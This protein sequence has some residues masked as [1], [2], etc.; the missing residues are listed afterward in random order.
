MIDN[1][2]TKT[3]A[4]GPETDGRSRRAAALRRLRLLT[5]ARSLQGRLTAARWQIWMALLSS[6]VM[7]TG[8]L[9]LFYWSFRFLFQIEW[10]SGYVIEL[11]FGLFFSALWAMLI[12]S[13]SI[14]IYSSLFS[15]NDARTMLIGPIPADEVF[16]Y[17]FHEVMLFSCWGFLMLGSPMIITYGVAVSAPWSFYPLSAGFL[18]A[19]CLLSGSLGSLLCMLVIRLFPRNRKQAALLL[20]V[21]LSLIAGG[22]TYAAWQQVAGQSLSRNSLIQLLEQVQLTSLPVLP[23]HWMSQGI[24]A[25]TREEDLVRPIMFLLLVTSHAFLSY[26]IATAVYRRG[27]RWA[28]D[29]LQ[30]HARRGTRTGRTL[31]YTGL[32]RLLSFLPTGIRAVVIKDIKT[33]ARDPIQFLQLLI[34]T[35]LLCLYIITLGSSQV[36]SQNPF[37]KN[38]VGLLNLLVMGLFLNVFTSRFVFPLLSLEGQKMWVLGLAPI[39]RLA[40]MWA[41]L[42]LSAAGSSLL[43]FLLTLLNVQMLRL[44]PLVTTIQFLMVPVLCWGGSGVGVGLGARFSDLK[45]T[46]PSKIAAGLSGTLNLVVSLVYMVL[47][48]GLIAV[49]SHL[50]VLVRDVQTA[51]PADDLTRLFSVSW[52]EH[53]LPLQWASAEAWL[54]IGAGLSVLLCVVSVWIPMRLGA[55]AFRDMEV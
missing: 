53:D 39:S 41:K 30:S 9:M 29:T 46:D 11:L 21:V 1:T 28:Y 15:A 6:L 23:P 8:L 47:A 45:Q 44:D 51:S 19:F 31:A 54:A 7:W 22:N 48:I 14:L 25:A 10:F 35:G 36:Y 16:A 34:L 12:F 4:A 42:A 33:F 43:L 13:S 55:N 17:K 50:Y 38:V 3:T 24:Q 49:P 32:E 40:I 5:L 52:I 27:Y 2:T 37:W 18:L 20:A 26:L